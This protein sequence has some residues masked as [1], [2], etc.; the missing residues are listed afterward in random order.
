MVLFAESLL[1]AIIIILFTMFAHSHSEV[2]SLL[3]P[4]SADTALVG[5]G[6]SYQPAADRLS[7]LDFGTS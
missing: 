4:C 6:V 1:N 2:S 7:W 5:G 3:R